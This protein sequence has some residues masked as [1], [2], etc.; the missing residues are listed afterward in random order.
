MRELVPQ[1][2]MLQYLG[3]GG[4]DVLQR[5]RAEFHEVTGIEPTGVGFEMA[6]SPEGKG[7]GHYFR[8]GVQSFDDLPKAK[9]AFEKCEPAHPLKQILPHN[10]TVAVE[11]CAPVPLPHRARNS[12]IL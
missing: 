11:L 4:P 7:L 6:I 5:L 9:A 2:V 3:E 1:E 12:I 10:V 8:F